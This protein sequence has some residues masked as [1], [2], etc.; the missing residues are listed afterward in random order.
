M[1][2]VKSSTTASFTVCPARLVP[3]PRGSTA[4]PSASQYDST[5]ATSSV[6]AGNTTPTGVTEYRLASVAYSSRE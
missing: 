6:L 3:P 1:C 4:T 5:A 2:I